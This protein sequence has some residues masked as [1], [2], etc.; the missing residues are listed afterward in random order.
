MESK[1]KEKEGKMRRVMV[2]L[3]I[4]FVIIGV[5]QA[6]DV[7]TNEKGKEKMAVPIKPFLPARE[8]SEPVKYSPLDELITPL[9]LLLYYAF[10][11]EPGE[12]IFNMNNGWT[13]SKNKEGE[14]F[15]QEGV[16]EIKGPNGEHIII[17]YKITMPLK[18]EE[19]AMEGPNGKAI[20]NKGNEGNIAQ[21]PSEEGELFPQEGEI[22]IKGPNGESI[23][24]HY[25]IIIPS[26]PEEIAE[27]EEEEK[28]AAV[29]AGGA[30]GAVLST[31][32]P[33]T[34]TIGEWTFIVNKGGGATVEG[35]GVTMEFDEE[36][37]LVRVFGKGVTLEKPEKRA[38]EKFYEEKK[39]EEIQPY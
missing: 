34:I 37:N 28:P 32:E 29:L 1:N 35:P 30:L 10:D 23:T 4:F 16:I 13:I 31:L 38:E 33:G 19:I 3:I 14:L 17:Y 21:R 2:N 36:F 7:F 15:P 24:I 6:A 39:F 5:A 26:K 11:L 27:E 25:T 18:Q 8:I 9:S 20:V 22:E 12:S